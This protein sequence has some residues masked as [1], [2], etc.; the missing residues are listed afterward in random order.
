VKGKHPA[1]SRLW[2][3]LVPEKGLDTGAFVGEGQGQLHVGDVGRQ[4]RQIGS[5]LLS[6]AAQG[7]P[8]RLGLN[9]AHRFAVHEEEVID[10]ACCKGELTDRDTQRSAQVDGV[11]VLDNPSSCFKQLVNLFA[12]LF[13]WC[14]H[15][16][17]CY[18]GN[19]AL[20]EQKRAWRAR[21]H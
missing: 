9:H 6:H 20:L 15:Q 21:A 11:A 8:L 13:L 7:G 16:S 3:A 18:K 17:T 19:S 12:C 14:G 4:A 5:R 10:V 1:A 2:V